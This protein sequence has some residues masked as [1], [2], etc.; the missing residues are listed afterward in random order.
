VTITAFTDEEW[1]A[2][3]AVCDDWSP[4]IQWTEVRQ[5]IEELRRGF[6]LMRANRMKRP[7]VEE[8]NKLKRARGTLQKLQSDL[9]DDLRNITDLAPLERAIQNRLTIYEIWGEKSFKGRA[10]SHRALVY[11]QLLL[12]W[13]QRLGRSLEFSRDVHGVPTGPLVQFLTVALNAIMGN[14]APGPLGISSLIEKERHRRRKQRLTSV[15]K[16]WKNFRT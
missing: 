5:E 6:W 7:P 11:D 4:H 2:I 16:R 8:R 1:A 14:E 15:L 13:T 9:P 12:I 3:R 10:D